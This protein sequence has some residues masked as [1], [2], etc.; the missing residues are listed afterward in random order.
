MFFTNLCLKRTDYCVINALVCEK[1]GLKNETGDFFVF[2]TSGI[3][4]AFFCFSFYLIWNQFLKK[5]TRLSTGLQILRKKISDLENLSLTVE[6]QIGRQIAV[7]NQKKH[8]LEN[9]LKTAEAL[10]ERLEKNL[11]LNHSLEKYS[12]YNRDRKSDE[13]K[14]NIQNIPKRIKPVSNNPC[15][16]KNLFEEKKLTRIRPVS[17]SHLKMVKKQLKS[18]LQFG[19]SPFTDLSFVESTD[20]NIKSSKGKNSDRP[21]QINVDP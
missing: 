14:Q 9:L 5:D 15:E 13:K 16:I 17:R 20:K 10:C 8:Q 4:I 3:I 1:N 21:V 6:A 2:F 7:A 19:E 11:E 12:T 18:D